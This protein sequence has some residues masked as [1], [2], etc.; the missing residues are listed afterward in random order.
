MPNTEQMA[1]FFLVGICNFHT[2]RV[3]SIKIEIS[4]M[5]LKRHVRRILSE[6]LVQVP[7]VIRVFQNFSIGEHK[8]TVAQNCAKFHNTI[9]TISDQEPHHINGL[10][11][12]CGAK[13]RR[14]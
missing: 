6:K 3:G 5:M 13:I 14:Y 4:V 7:S 8:K 9:R 11:T 12:L 1:Y 10:S 2:A